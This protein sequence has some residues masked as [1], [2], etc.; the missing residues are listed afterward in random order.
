M[1][2]AKN[3]ILSYASPKIRV[4]D[5]KQLAEYDA[6]AKE[7]RTNAALRAKLNVLSEDIGVKWLCVENFHEAVLKARMNNLKT[8]IPFGKWARRYEQGGK[9]SKSDAIYK[10]FVA[11]RPKVLEHIGAVTYT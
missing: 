6:L 9:V 11:M 2:D 5:N 10:L 7:V 4:I 3:N 1:F 8:F